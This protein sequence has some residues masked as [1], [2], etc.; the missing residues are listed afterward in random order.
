MSNKIIQNQIQEEI[1]KIDE[2]NIKI[3]YFINQDK[4]IYD[5]ELNEFINNNDI[6][7]FKIMFFTFISL[8]PTCIKYIKKYNNYKERIRNLNNDIEIH[9]SEYIKRKIELF[10][11]VCGKVEGRELD[12][13]QIDAIVREDRNQL[14]I[15]GAGCGKTTSIVGKVK[16]LVKVLNVNPKDILLLSFTR[17]SATDMKNR[18]EQEIGTKMECYTFHKL[19]LE[20]TKQQLENPNIYDGSMNRFIK[21]QIN[22][23]VQNEDYLNKLVYFITENV[24][25]IKDEFSIRSEEEYKKYIE[26]NPPITIKGEIVKSYGEMEIANF[27]FYNDVN[28]EYETKYEYETDTSE[29]GEYHPDFYLPDYGIYIEYFG[30]DRNNNVPAYFTSRHGKTPKEEYNDGIKWKKELHKSHNTVLIDLYYYENKE[31]TLKEVL[32]NQLIKN[33]VKLKQVTINN[34]FN[35]IKEKNRGIIDNLSVSFETIINLIKSNDYKIDDLKEKANNYEY[36]ENIKVTLDLIHPIYD[37]Y[38]ELLARNKMID[39]NDMINLATSIIA[40]GLYSNRFKYVIVDEFQ[41]ISNS[42]YKLLKQLR[43]SNDYKLYCVGDDFQSIY[44]FTGSDIGIFTS[45]QKYFGPVG[46][47]IISR[48]HRF[49]NWLAEISGKFIMQNPNQIKKNLS[50]FQSNIFPVAEVCAYKSIYT[51]S[52]LEEKLNYFTKNSS[53]LFLGRYNFDIDLLRENENFSYFYDKISEKQK[54]VYKKRKDLNIE[55]MTIHSSKGLEADYVI[56]LN[57]R[58][59]RMGFPNRMNELPIMTMLLDNSDN[60]P[61][62]EERRLFYVALTRARKK[63]FLLVE[64]NNKSSFIKELEGDYNN[65]FKNEK[66]VCPLC[67]G[68][69]SIKKGSYSKFYGCSNYPDCRYTKSIK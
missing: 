59:K 58:N 56:V 2:K 30:I 54:I 6:N 17:K 66:Y 18:V 64:E 27:L 13:E 43:E 10:K 51:I 41:D 44:R 39:F 1:N 16:Y 5:Y 11:Q 69:L 52:F 4:Y 68:H 67:N 26:T 25:L 28:Y 7:K 45:F 23:Y 40:S 9:N 15:A 55:F 46:I 31:G 37:E 62:S 21:E 33:D 50:G 53:V 57:N 49:S 24:H 36:C 34:V 63:V 20:I 35:Y 65:F 32:K 29:Y 14:V 22:K 47:N 3:D 38:D 8:L 12:N 48:T 19:G 60:Y 42:R 61:F